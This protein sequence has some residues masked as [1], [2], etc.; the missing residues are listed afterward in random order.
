MFL[1][2]AIH[3]PSPDHVDDF[4]DHMER[5]IAATEGAEGLIEFT[6]WRDVETD[7]LLGIARWESE[8]AFRA[9]LP[10]IGSLAD[11]RRPEWTVADDEL[12]TLTE[13]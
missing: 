10:R 13:N 9:A 4:V 1:T 8:A 3:H 6:S 12:L 11:R 7:R 2:I 5:V